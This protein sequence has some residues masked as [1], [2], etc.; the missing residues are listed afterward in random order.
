MFMF[1]LF[2]SNYKNS[3]YMYVSFLNHTFSLCL[4]SKKQISTMLLY[5]MYIN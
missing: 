3:M 4:F 1:D 5:G 2:E